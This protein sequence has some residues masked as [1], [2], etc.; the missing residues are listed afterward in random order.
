M[1]GDFIGFDARGAHMM[2]AEAI[3]P[4]A[5]VRYS[6]VRI[7][8]LAETCCRLSRRLFDIADYLG[9]TIETVSRI[10]FSFRRREIVALP[11]ASRVVIL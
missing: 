11:S 6:R 10:F 8:R 5:V 9:L 1:E 4:V 7:E 2:S 3:T